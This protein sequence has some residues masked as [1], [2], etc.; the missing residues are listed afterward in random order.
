[1]S[2]VRRRSRSDPSRKSPRA[3]E[4]Y[5]H[6]SRIFPLRSLPHASAASRKISMAAFCVH[7]GRGP[8]LVFVSALHYTIPRGKV[9]GLFFDWIFILHRPLSSPEARR[10]GR[11]VSGVFVR[12][13]GR[14]CGEEF[15]IQN[16]EFRIAEETASGFVLFQAR[17][18]PAAPFASTKSKG[19]THSNCILGVERIFLVFSFLMRNWPL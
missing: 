14:S 9:Q 12:R 4:P 3:Q 17:T 8:L 16:E 2:A 5:R 10:N 7:I 18:R 1:M 15:R 6:A 13:G 11:S 19:L